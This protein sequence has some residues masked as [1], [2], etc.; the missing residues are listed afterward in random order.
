VQKR[1]ATLCFA[2]LLACGSWTAAVHAAETA[3]A[4]QASPL[5]RTRARIAAG[6]EVTVVLYGDSISEVGR[7]PR[8]H[9]GA[10]SSEAN[11]GGQLVRLLAVAHPGARFKAVHFAIGGQNTYEGLGRLDGLEPLAPDLVLVAFGANDCCH[12]YLEPAET[13]LALESLA[14]DIRKRFDADVIVVGTGGDNPREPFFRHLPE[15]LAAQRRAADAA[16][17]PFV[18]VRQPVLAATESGAKWAD[19]HCGPA[20][21]HP[22]DAGHR[23]WAEAAF[24]RIQ[25][26]L[27]VTSSPGASTP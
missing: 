14:K 22:N 8:W 12:H 21:C 24:T 4:E 9:G 25:E 1:V 5:P 19:F 3:T 7:S 26:L 15:T 11:W 13:A 27:Q 6:G 18:D 16:G 2:L 17:V 23:V 20:N 10:G